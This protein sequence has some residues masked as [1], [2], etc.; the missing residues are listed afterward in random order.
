MYRVQ[1]FSKNR[2]FIYDLLRRATKFHCPFSSTIEVDCSRAQELLRELRKNGQKVSFTAY[3]VK[4]TGHL[5]QQF[6]DLN[7]HLFT[8]LLGTKTIVRFDRISC[9]MVVQRSLPDGEKILL[10]L[11][12]H[13]PEKLTLVE[14]EKII[15]HHRTAPLTELPQFAAYE[16]IKR[17]PVFL[18]KFIS[19]KTRSDPDFYLKYYGTYGLSTAYSFKNAATSGSAVANTAV[20]FLPYGL[21]EE[22]GKRML[23]IGL[24]M[25]HFVL[26]GQEMGEAGYYLKK[27]VENP[28]QIVSHG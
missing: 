22:G 16:R 26:D 19:F 8:S 12:I 10:P 6:P 7:S 3:M 9:N 11:I 24:V 13:D 4:V 27:L 2:Q 14:I 15:Q 25:D 23:R 18:L 5:L 21:F 17:L 28:E 1:K 20:A